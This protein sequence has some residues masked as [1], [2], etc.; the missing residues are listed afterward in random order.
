MKH[1]GRLE[2]VGLAIETVRGTIETTPQKWV[3]H[4]TSDITSKAEVIVDE[5][6]MGILEDSQNSRVVKKWFEGSLEGTLHVDAL[7]YLLLNIYGDVNSAIESG[8][9]YTHEFT[10]EQDIEHQS[11]T[12][13]RKD[14]DATQKAYGGAVV[15]TLEIS[16][17]TGSLIKLVA[18]IICA[19]E[20]TNASSPSYDEEYDF[21]GR[22]VSFK[23]E[24][25]E[26]S[27][28]SGTPV[29]IKELKI[30]YDTGAISDFNLG[31][32]SPTNYNAKMSIEVEIK[33]SFMDAT[34]EDLWK[35]GAAKYIE[36]TIEGEAT[37]GTAA[38][39]TIVLLLNKAIVQDWSR[40]GGANDLVD[41]TI[42]LKGFYNTIDTQQSK[43]TITNLTPSYIPAI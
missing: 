10:M 16:A 30:S 4:I 23:M 8:I 21:I 15:N 38:K 22:D 11:L 42:K 2:A 34:F 25:D 28:V 7:G 18:S 36:I 3:K 43:I 13:F 37:I 33:K 14:G 20:G 40:S 35:S 12:I 32:Y 1:S 26:A 24:D 9:A 27:L 39:P 5:N 31:S 6:V 41:E 19:T 17:T 29:E